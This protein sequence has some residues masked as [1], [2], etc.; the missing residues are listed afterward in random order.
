MYPSVISVTPNTDFMLNIVFSNGESGTLDMKPYL[1]FGVFNKLKD[2]SVF[3]R[4]MVVFDTVEWEVGVD[5]D[6]EFVY[7]KCQLIVKTEEKQPVL[8]V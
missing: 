4:V 7:G 5:L 3:E 6:P 8:M 2:Y 1:E